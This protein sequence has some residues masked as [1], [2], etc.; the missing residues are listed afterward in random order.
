MCSYC[1]SESH[2]CLFYAGRDGWGGP[3]ERLVLSRGVTDAPYSL[4][5]QTKSA[6]AA[7]TFVFISMYFMCV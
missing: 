4:C 5:I 7:K 3:G 6:I 1:L 2:A